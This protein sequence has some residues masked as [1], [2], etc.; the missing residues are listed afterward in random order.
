MVESSPKN[1]PDRSGGGG[2]GT[3]RCELDVGPDLGGFVEV[4]VDAGSDHSAEG[5]VGLVVKPV[6]GA[7]DGDCLLVGVPLQLLMAE[8]EGGVADI[9]G[10][11]VRS[12]PGTEP[13]RDG[14]GTG[15]VDVGLGRRAGED[16]VLVDDGD[17]VVSNARLSAL[18]CQVWSGMRGWRVALGLGAERRGPGGGRDGRAAR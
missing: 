5:Q 17:G 4:A 3:R 18:R 13:G 14:G 10:R 6:D 2:G 1:G 9:D 12:A 8:P 16:G 7:V 11:A 15:Q